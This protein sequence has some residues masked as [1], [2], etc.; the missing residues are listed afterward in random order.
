M[1]SHFSHKKDILVGVYSVQVA[2]TCLVRC[3]IL[4]FAHT[5][6]SVVCAKFAPNF[7]EFLQKYCMDANM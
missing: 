3:T 1:F 6:I 4:V 7:I 2:S 5:H